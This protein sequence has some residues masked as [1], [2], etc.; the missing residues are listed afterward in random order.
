M[1]APSEATTIKLSV[2]VENAKTLMIEK[3]YNEKTIENYNR[4]WGQLMEYADIEG[5]AS[6]SN[7][8]LT[9]FARSKYGI[10]NVF[11]PVTDKEKYYARILLCLYD[12]S[13]TGTWITHRTYSLPKQFRS[14]TFLEAYESYTDWLR[15]KALKPGSISLKQLIVRDFLFFAETGLVHT[16]SELSQ[17]IVLNYLETKNGLSPSTKSGII[18]TLRDFLMHLVTKAILSKDLSVNLKATN[19]GKYEH[20]PSAYSVDEIRS[21]LSSIDRVTTE[22]K[23]DYAVILLAVD[24]GMRISDIINL[25]LLDIKWDARTIE[26]VQEKT[27]EFL[28]LAMSNA[29]KWALLDYLIYAR[30][31]DTSFKNVFLRSVAPVAPYVSAG[32][33]YKRLNKYFKAAGINTE[34]K[35][36]GMHALRHNLATRLMRDNVPITVISE[37]LGHKY[38]NVTKQYIRVDVEKLRLAA[39]EV[40]SNG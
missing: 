19:N 28:C 16:I 37:A 40:I 6:C 10:K 25:K 30:S 15:G 9:H 23:K 2:Q 26:I 35:H 39:L 4:V 14:R 24:T 38:A 12:S 36:H 3:G 32:H 29:L 20:L 13:I 1:Q 31:K 27:G 5:I 8:L 18:I 17:A 34:G 7:N 21:I 22:G 33:Y 11:L